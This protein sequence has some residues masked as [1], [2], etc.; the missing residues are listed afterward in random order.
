LSSPTHTSAGWW[1]PSKQSH[2]NL[3]KI[4]MVH[5]A[6]MSF[7]P[8]LQGKAVQIRCNNIAT[9]AHLNHMGGRSPPMN[10]VMRAIHQLCKSSHIQLTATYLPGADNTV[11]DRLWPHHKWKL[12]PAMFCRLYQCW[13]PHTIN[14]TASASNSQLPHFNSQF[15]EA[16]RRQWIACSKT[17]A[18][19]TTGL[20]PLLPLSHASST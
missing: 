1:P 4:T 12:A 20:L 16:E 17:G 5:N 11:A 18:R 10:K 14:K 3:L 19:T 8:L 15:S 6:L 7:L 13:G 2:I 9:V